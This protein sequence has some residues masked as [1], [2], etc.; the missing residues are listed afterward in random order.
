MLQCYCSLKGSRVDNILFLEEDVRVFQVK[1]FMK[2]TESINKA[3]ELQVMLPDKQ[4]TDV[5][6]ISTPVSCQQASE[7]IIV[8]IEQVEEGNSGCWRYVI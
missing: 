4:G 5:A 7:S 2:M 6:S 1:R 8:Q 3:I